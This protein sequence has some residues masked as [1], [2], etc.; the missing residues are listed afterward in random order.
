MRK[1][2]FLEWIQKIAAAVL[3][4]LAPP[5]PFPPTQEQEFRTVHAKRFLPHRRATLLITLF[6][7]SI[8]AYG[9]GL[10]MKPKRRFIPR[11]SL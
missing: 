5:Q 9:I 3:E 7:W 1:F 10:V 11:R 2:V 4:T 6:T 8:F